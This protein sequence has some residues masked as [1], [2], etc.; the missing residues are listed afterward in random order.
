LPDG[1]QGFSPF[2]QTRRPL[3]FMA[4]TPPTSMFSEVATPTMPMM[5]QSVEMMGSQFLKFCRV[6]GG[7]GGRG[8]W[9]REGVGQ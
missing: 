5:G 2:G 7:G 8:R 4:T 3:E 6:V 1:T 9:W